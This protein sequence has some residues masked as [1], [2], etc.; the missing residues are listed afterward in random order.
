[1]LRSFFDLYLFSLK[2][3][4]NDIYRIPFALLD[5]SKGFPMLHAVISMMKNVYEFQTVL[6]R[7]FGIDIARIAYRTFEYIENYPSS[8]HRNISSLAQYLWIKGI[9]VTSLFTNPAELEYLLV[10]N[11]K[12]AIEFFTSDIL[13]DASSLF[14]LLIIILLVIYTHN[15]AIDLSLLEKYMTL[16]EHSIAKSQSD[17]LPEEQC[18]EPLV[19]IQNRV[20]ETE[21]C[22]H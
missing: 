11:G 3:I 15:S 13:V 14:V 9:Y 10:T 4:V 18:D 5:Y 1:M 2:F 7:S 22:C 6:L 19:P 8:F 12:M 20:L 21:V 17:I 16:T